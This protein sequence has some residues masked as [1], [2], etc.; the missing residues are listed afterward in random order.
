MGP[1]VQ[2]VG[3]TVQLV[4]LAVQ[5]VNFDG[6]KMGFFD[7]WQHAVNYLWRKPAPLYIVA[8]SPTGCR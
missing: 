6:Q 4:G 5:L 3:F 1:I 2:L 7:G 8:S